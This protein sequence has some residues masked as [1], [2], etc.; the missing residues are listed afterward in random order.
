MT[1][2]WFRSGSHVTWDALDTP[3]D[4][5]TEWF[6]ANAMIEQ[7]IYGFWSSPFHAIASAYAPVLGLM[8]AGMSFTASR[9]AKVSYRQAFAKAPL[10]VQLCTTFAAIGLAYA[11]MSSGVQ[12]FI[13]FQF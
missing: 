9:S 10:W 4:I 7:L 5:W 13:Y 6:T 8:A 1:R 2:I 12:P 11:G 3:H